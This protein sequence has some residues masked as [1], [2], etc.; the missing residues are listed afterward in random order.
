MGKGGLAVR[1]LGCLVLLS[2]LGVAVAG[3][4]HLLR[5]EPPSVSSNGA[6][7][8]RY[9]YMGSV[10]ALQ[11]EAGQLRVISAR[12]SVYGETATGLNRLTINGNVQNPYARTYVGEGDVIALVGARQ[13]LAVTDLGGPHRPP[14]ALGATPRVVATAS[15]QGDVALL[16]GDGSLHL[17]PGGDK[18]RELRL[19]PLAGRS[20]LA[21]QADLLLVGGAG[22]LEVYGEDGS[23]RHSLAASSIYDVTAV[24]L[25]LDGKRAAAARSDEAIE[26]W[27]LES[28]ELVSRFLGGDDFDVVALAFAP[29]G[30]S[31]AGGSARGLIQIWNREGVET[32]RLPLDRSELGDSSEPGRVIGLAFDEARLLW[33]IEDRVYEYVLSNPPN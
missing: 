20:H 11:L 25:S 6:R 28:G 9:Q 7:I 24:A 2:L 4:T 33:A 29:E 14:L 23:L 3:V 1:A 22:A 5:S 32:L 21:Y 16:F 30:A 31:L 12:G 13:E 8:I 27:N 10:H 19:V 26:V 17:L 18:D 15:D